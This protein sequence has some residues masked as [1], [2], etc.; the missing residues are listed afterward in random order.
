MLFILMGNSMYTHEY[1]YI[2]CLNIDLPIHLI[3][4]YTSMSL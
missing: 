2:H 1:V 4:E 3:L